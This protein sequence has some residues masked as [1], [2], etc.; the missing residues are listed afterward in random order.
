MKGHTNNPAGRPIGSKNK[1]TGHLREAI[2]S[3]IEDNF[4][5]VVQ[6]WRTLDPKDKLNFYRDLIQYV[7]PKMQTVSMQAKI[8]QELSSLT[9]DQLDDLADR[10]LM[11]KSDSNE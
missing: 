9:D 2:T 1:A 3:F 5:E 10:M 4:D 11:L 8:N 6:D 7:M